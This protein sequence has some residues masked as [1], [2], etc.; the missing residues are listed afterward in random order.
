MTVRGNLTSVTRYSNAAAGTGA[1]TRSLTYDTLGNMRTAQVDCCNQKTFNFGSANQYAYPNSVVRGSGALQFTTS[2]IYNVE[3]G[4]VLTSTDENGQVL[5]YQYDAMNRGTGVTL[6]PQSGAQV[7]QNT[8]FDDAAVSPTVTSSSTANSA[9]NVTTLDGLGHVM[10]VDNKNG[11]SMVGSVKYGY[12]KLWQRTQASNPFASADAIVNTTSSY[13]ALGRV[14]RVTP[15]SAG[16]TQYSYSGNTVTITDQAGKQ[17]RSSMDVLG[18]LTEVDEPGWGDAVQATGSVTISGREVFNCANVVRGRCIGQI[19]DTGTVSITVNGVT[20]SAPYGST[21]TSSTIATALATAINGDGNSPVTASVSG[22]TVNFTAKQGGANTN[23]SL[24]ASSSTNDPTDFGGPSFSGAPSSSTLTGGQ[25]AVSQ[26]SPTLARPMVTTYGYD[27]LSN[28]TSVSQAAMQLVNGQ[29]VA[30]QPRSYTYDSLSRQ[31]TATTPESGTVTNYYTMSDGV[32]ACAGD[33]SLLCRVQD[34]RGV[35]KTLSYDGIN[36]PLRVTYSDGTPVVIYAYDAGGAAAFAL[37]R[38]TSISEGPPYWLTPN[39]QTFAYDNFGRVTS[40]SQVIDQATYVTGYSYNLASQLTA[41]TYPTGRVIQQNVDAIGRLSS[42]SDGATYLSGLAYNAAGQPLGFTLGNGVQGSFGFNDHLQL[43]SLRYF[44]SGSSPDILNL[45]YDYGA[46]NNGQI[47]T[48]HSFTSPGAEDFTKSEK[49]TYDPLARLSAAQTT[50]VDSTPGT[51]SLQWSF[52]RLGNRLS[53]TLVGGNV[54]IGQP[55]FVIDTATNRI[56]NSGFT[57][58]A[59]GNITHDATSAY[60]YDGA[61]RL[62]QVGSGTAVY[63]Y[64]GPL[65]IKKVNGGTATVYI[66][67]GSKPI[68]EY[69]NGSSAPSKEY[70][71]AGTK[72]LATIAGSAT[73]YHHPDHLSNRA[74]T[75]A[76]GN[77][78]RSFGHFPHG[79]TW[80]ETGAGDKWK[81]TSYERDSGTGETGL[82][83]AQNRYYNPGQGRFIS[84]DPLG[85]HLEAPQSLNRYAYVMNDPHGT[86]STGL[87]CVWDD[88]SFDSVDDPET[89]SVGACQEAG[90][91]WIE[92][93]LGG[94]WTDQSQW[95]LAQITEDIRNGVYDIVSAPGRD[96]NPYVTKYDSQGRVEWTAGVTGGV[97]LVSFYSYFANELQPSDV[98]VAEDPGG[99]IASGYR[100]WLLA[101]PGKPIDLHDRMLLDL[102]ARI[103]FMSTNLIGRNLQERVCTGAQ[104]LGISLFFTGVG[105]AASPYGIDATV[106]G[107]L[108][109]LSGAN[110]GLALS[111]YCGGVNGPYHP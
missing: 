31:L 34:A 80:Y 108:T 1:I 13:D 67:S 39:S 49:F 42:I 91:T 18:R 28:L 84:P 78:V 75:D 47:Q 45:G 71:Y 43:A 72:L 76:S 64:F 62:T 44:K 65:R 97:G 106:K 10:R 63:T 58:D 59:A 11:S 77:P 107:V 19:W 79:E 33:P 20:D 5:Q 36:R 57:Y 99:T 90:G 102:A 26:G 86:D 46:N 32:T 51:W 37:G 89:G 55:N 111:G 54:S 85:G 25:D 9:V 103:D 69:V 104:I 48:V 24:S 21:S 70:I 50:Q 12:D 6:P 73:T 30:G 100:Q 8:A 98:R 27:A 29:P 92:L 53:Q 81:F 2:A 68:V 15:P 95:N 16:Y 105:A 88:G 7:Q 61:N 87:E 4:L 40:I 82:D 101:H 109:V 66:Y 3:K 93:G 74:E 14:T 41:I 110:Q 22:S 83:Y 52:D 17:R 96:G 23:Y 38:L 35:V 60:T 56:I 94:L